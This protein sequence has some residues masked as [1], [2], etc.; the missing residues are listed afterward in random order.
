MGKRGGSYT[1]YWTVE[2]APADRVPFHSIPTSVQ[3]RLSI[4]ESVWGTLPAHVQQLVVQDGGH[5]NDAGSQCTVYAS[6]PKKKPSN[7]IVASGSVYCSGD[8]VKVRLDVSLQRQKGPYWIGIAE[9]NVGW[10]DGRYIG[11]G[12]NGPCATGGHTY[13]NSVRG[14]ME[15]SNQQVSYKR[16]TATASWYCFDD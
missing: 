9:V 13:R 5:T 3:A 1:L 6:K 2:S 4:P 10:T 14:G 15:D 11:R 7:R 12:V 8:V 16:E